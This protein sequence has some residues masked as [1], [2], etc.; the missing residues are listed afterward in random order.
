MN[1]LAY[2]LV[3]EGGYW[4]DMAEFMSNSQYQRAFAVMWPD[5]VIWDS[6]VGWRYDYM[7]EEIN[8][9]HRLDR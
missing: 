6:I 5:G 3:R 2:A 1:P 8:A 7:K 4:L 9:R